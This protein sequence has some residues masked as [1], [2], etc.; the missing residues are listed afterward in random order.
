[1]KLLKEHQKDKIELESKVKVV[2]ID[3]VNKDKTIAE[4][5]QENS[6]LKQKAKDALLASERIKI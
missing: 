5:Q 1:M 4:L 2:T 6:V 3:L